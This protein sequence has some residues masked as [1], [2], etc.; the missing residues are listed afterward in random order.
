M[1]SNDASE[2]AAAKTNWLTAAGNA[3]RSASAARSP[4]SAR[5][6]T[7]RV[8]S[9]AKAREGLEGLQQIGEGAHIHFVRRAWSPADATAL[10]EALQE[11][12]AWS[13]NEITVFGN[14]HKEPRLTCYQASDP[15]L[16]YTYSGLDLEPLPFSP[17]VSSVLSRV[18]ELFPDVHFNSVLCNR[19][20]SGEDAM[21]WHSDED[22]PRY[23]ESPNIVSCSFGAERDFVLRRRADSADKLQ[24]V[25]GHGAVLL[26]GG[27]CQKTWQ[28]SVPRRKNCAERINLTFRFIRKAAR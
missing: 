24:Y 18:T 11:E 8:G 4:E 9:V 10:F 5:G 7:A 2:P 21:G 1:V 17:A 28:H 14:R 25:L 20:R 19:Y 13:Q 27:T 15:S 6:K 16:V 23:G 22:V 26:M 3:A 12:V